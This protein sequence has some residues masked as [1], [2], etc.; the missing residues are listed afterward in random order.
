MNVMEAVSSS[1][2]ERSVVSDV[3]NT[4]LRILKEADLQK[5]GHLT[6]TEFANILMNEDAVK[7]FNRLGVDVETFAQISEFL[8]EEEAQ[9]DTVKTQGILKKSQTLRLMEDD[10]S[11]RMIAGVIR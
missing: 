2:K 10:L 6:Y 7:A 4:I 1:E 5:Q 9:E 3:K 11:S 8:F